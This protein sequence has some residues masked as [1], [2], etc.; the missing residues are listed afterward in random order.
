VSSPAANPT[1]FKGDLR[2]ALLDNAAQAV[3]ENG[4]AGVSLR[5]IARRVGVSHAAPAHHF[6]DKSGLFTALAA[7]GFRLLE[8]AIGEAIAAAADEGPVDRLVLA[9]QAYLRMAALH[10]SHYAIMFRADL[11]H[12][13][14]PTLRAEAAR[15]FGRL[16]DAVAEIQAT[17]WAGGSDTLDLAVGAWALVHGL[18]TL[19]SAGALAALGGK[20]RVESAVAAFLA[21]AG[22]GAAPM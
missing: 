11:L 13:D 7:E 5:D 22:V 21:G 18:A 3:A 17:G 4:P 12:N 1:Y 2:R 20:R 19:E 15:A 8:E 14:D 6:G 16:V 9:G 10:P